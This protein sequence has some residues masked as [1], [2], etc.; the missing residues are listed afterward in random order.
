MELKKEEQIVEASLLHRMEKNII[1]ECRRKE[2][3]GRERRGRGHKGGRIRYWKRKEVRTEDRKQIEICSNGER[4]TGL[5][6]H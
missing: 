1:R 5:S 4:Q 2:E 3:T 6:S